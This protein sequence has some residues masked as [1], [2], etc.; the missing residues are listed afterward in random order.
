MIPFYI[1]YLLIEKGLCTY[2]VSVSSMS[3]KSKTTN[4]GRE[5]YEVA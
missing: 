4:G 5:F 1:L 3:P 2:E